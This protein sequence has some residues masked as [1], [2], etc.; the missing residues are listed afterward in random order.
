MSLMFLPHIPV[1]ASEG[2]MPEVLS[3]AIARSQPLHAWMIRLWEGAH[4]R[5]DIYW[6]RR[7][8]PF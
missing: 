1:E 6:P 5:T 4:D 7:P 8:D 3:A 2:R